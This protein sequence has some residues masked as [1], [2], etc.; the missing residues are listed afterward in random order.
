MGQK[1]FYFGYL[2]QIG[3]NR[4]ALSG[5]LSRYFTRDPDG[6]QADVQMSIMVQ[7]TREQKYKWQ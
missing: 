5:H 2:H 3:S 1:N 7:N 6:C 4:T